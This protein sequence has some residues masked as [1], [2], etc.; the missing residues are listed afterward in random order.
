MFRQ[1]TSNWIGN[2]LDLNIM[3]TTSDRIVDTPHTSYSMGTTLEENYWVANR[4]GWAENKL[5]TD[6]TMNFTVLNV[7]LSFDDKEELGFIVSNIQLLNAI[8]LAVAVT[9]MILFICTFV[10]KVFSRYHDDENLKE[11]G[12]TMY[13][14]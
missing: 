14:V 10:L 5:E 1:I 12:E 8:V 3:E 4:S 9:L 13:Y 11:D 2:T 6:R 7:T